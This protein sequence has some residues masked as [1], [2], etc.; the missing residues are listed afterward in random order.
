MIRTRLRR[1]LIAILV[2]TVCV[3]LTS[4]LAQEGPDVGARAKEIVNRMAD[5][6]GNA[7]WTLVSELRSLKR[8]A[9]P[10]VSGMI[11]G[12]SPR[13]K[14]GAAAALVDLGERT[15]GIDVLLDLAGPDHPTDIR[16]AAIAV[17]GRKA[18][19]D[20][21]DRLVPLLD[22]AFDSRVRIALAKTL[23]ELTRDLKAK[24]ELKAVLAS[25]DADVRIE[26]ALALAEIGDYETAKP[27][28]ETVADEPTPR[29]RMARALLDEAQ[30]REFYMNKKA[31]AGAEPTAKAPVYTDALLHQIMAY[32]REFY[33]DAP[34][35]TDAD[36]L[37]AAAHG[38]TES[39][40]IH[41]TYFAA[42][43]RFDWQEDLN[44]IYGG[45]GS[46]VGTVDEIFTITR[47]MFGG[48]AYK[49]GLKPG[50]QI[51]RV[52]GWETAGH[53]NEEIINHL[54][55]EPGTEV[56]VTIYRKGWQ[57]T[58][59]FKIARAKIQVP[60]VTSRM[61]PG[62]VGYTRLATFGRD[63][64]EEL[65]QD[66]RNMEGEGMKAFILDLR[67]NGGGYL[68]TAR[69]ICDLFLDRGKLIV[70]SEGR[71]QQVAPRRELRTTSATTHPDYPVIILV[72][73]A[74]ASA[75]EI[76]SGCL[77][78]Y[79]R[80]ELV[81]LRTYGKGSVQ[82][83][84]PIYVSPPAEPWEDV[85]GNGMYDDR[86]LF[87]DRNEN[88]RY[89]T[90]EN[91]YDRNGNGRWDDAEPYTDTNGNHH[92]DYPA[93]KL[94]IAK[95]FLPNGVSLRR[96]QKEV[97][98]KLQW[99]GGLDPDVWIA[100]EEPDGW[101][102]EELAR[103]EE[104]G[105]FDAYLDRQYPSH[106]E[107]FQKL[108]EFDGGT[109]K[110]YPEFEEFYR[111]LGTKLEQNDVWWWLRIKLRRKVGDLQGRELVGDYEQDQ[112]L[113]VAILSALKKVGTDAH[114]IDEYVIFS[115]KEFPEVSED[116]RLADQTGGA[117]GR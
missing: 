47:P 4:T 15:K 8:E 83:I 99:I 59:D 13:A 24:E 73:G 104:E 98:G 52:D 75:S 100:A 84:Y 85:N 37:E 16:I 92:F 29:G 50:D 23:Y 43:Q 44:P 77:Q 86:E 103:L 12:L 54:R 42:K 102:N 45:I 49:A 64:A 51:L 17:L 114:T 53:T 94:T 69:K 20:I 80:A 71:N 10:A 30:W 19:D 117:E 1:T 89:D 58:R 7:L 39:L 55:G 106:E 3:P 40:D 96:E 97:N 68:D 88:G 14:L 67:F 101:R 87:L 63:S 93:L 62:K 78:F 18:T 113:Q 110:G 25:T 5:A 9:A 70:Y 48:P 60:T 109:W 26:G 111:G 105:K 79:G 65:D 95:Y 28:L 34:D 66:L 31:A 35:L 22:N 115:D 107:I 38:I 57:K 56:I 2:M 41:S 36:L 32:I 72:N 116:Q 46:Y 61:L 112:Q 82:N 74:S 91:Y 6:E 90:G 81:G 27:I 76:T 11:D 33:L 21:E 108:A